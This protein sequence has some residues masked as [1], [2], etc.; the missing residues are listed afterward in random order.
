M[1]SRD[2]NINSNTGKETLVEAFGADIGGKLFGAAVKLSARH[3]VDLD[4]V[5]QDMTIEALWVRE[6]YAAQA[7][8]PGYI[9]INTVILRT[10]NALYAGKAGFRY[11]NNRYHTDR[12]ESEVCLSDLS[13]NNERRTQIGGD[14]EDYHDTPAEAILELLSSQVNYDLREQFTDTLADLPDTTRAVAVGLAA[15]YNKSEIAT[16]LGRSNA[17]VTGEVKKLQTAFGWAVA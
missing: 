3:N 17:F 11:G 12:G 14:D 13:L 4:D 8:T 7:Y 2:S 1:D 16:Q 15:G 5:I 9:N 6:H 10:K